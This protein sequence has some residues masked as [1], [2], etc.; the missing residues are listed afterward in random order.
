MARLL[1]AASYSDSLEHCAERLH[2]ERE[3]RAEHGRLRARLEATGLTITDTLPPSAMTLGTL[4]HDGGE[5]TAESHAGC[6]GHGAYF[7]S[8]DLANPVFYCADQETDKR[9]LNG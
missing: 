6:P 3:E 2:V 8:Y 7:A 9:Y 4:R 1:D 5:L